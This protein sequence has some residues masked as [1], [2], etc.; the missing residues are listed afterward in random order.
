VREKSIPPSS[1]DRK[2]IE[3]SFGR[4]HA[5]FTAVNSLRELT[6]SYALKE[7]KVTDLLSIAPV[8]DVPPSL[9]ESLAE[10]E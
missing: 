6:R 9:F 8:S 4:Y 7:K 2:E 1:T 10:G 5:S 3:R